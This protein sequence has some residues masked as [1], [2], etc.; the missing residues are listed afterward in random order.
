MHQGLKMLHEQR[1]LV[2]FTLVT[3]TVSI[4]LPMQGVVDQQAFM[5]FIRL[6][7]ATLFVFTLGL[8]GVGAATSATPYP[9]K[10]IRIVAPYAPGGG[11]D[12]IAR[13][14]AQHLSSAFK[15]TAFV[16]NRAGAGGRLGTELV[17]RAAPD[18]YTLLLTGSG[19][20]IIGPVMYKLPYDTQRDLAPITVV[21]TS[22]YILLVHPAVPANTVGQLITLARARPGTLNYA[23]SGL[24]APAHLAA[25]LFQAQARVK[26]THIAYKGTGPGVMSTLAGET[27]L[28]FSNMLGV[29]SAIKSGRLRAIAV[30]TRKRVALFPQLVTIA[31]SGLPDFELATYYGVFAPAGTPTDIIRQ[32]NTTLVRTLHTDDTRKRLEVDGSEVQT[33]T[34]EEFARIIRTDTEKWTRILKAAGIKPES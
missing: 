26:F 13:L 3:G 17:V 16:D 12:L 25:E 19:S 32:I 29:V 20:V 11:S 9:G 21:A 34:P 30:T 8:Q 31:E 28:M 7:V 15:Q 10:A 24:G 4:I 23:S 2:S 33:T 14:V 22:S 18:G 1:S 27:D 6:C 5:F